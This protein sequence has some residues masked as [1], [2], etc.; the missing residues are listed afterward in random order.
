MQTLSWQTGDRYRCEDG[1]VMEI[2]SASEAGLLCDAKPV[3][4]LAPHGFDTEGRSSH[5]CS[6]HGCT[7]GNLM[8][9]ISWSVGA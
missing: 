6:A 1:T 2:R 5:L 9:R 8:S 7:H 3:N 4:K